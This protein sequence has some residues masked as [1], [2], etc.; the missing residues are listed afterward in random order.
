MIFFTGSPSHFFIPVHAPTTSNGRSIRTTGVL[1][2]HM[3]TIHPLS[4][5]G[6]CQGLFYY[7]SP[8]ILDFPL[9]EESLIVHRR[10]ANKG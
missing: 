7:G 10:T 9:L 6:T 5:I 1:Y 8:V 4:M 3:E 2:N